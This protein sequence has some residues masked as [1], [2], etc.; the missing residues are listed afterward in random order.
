MAIITDEQIQPIV[1]EIAGDIALL[2]T[3]NAD[4][5]QQLNNKA[6]LVGGRVPS[7]QLPGY[8]DEVSEHVNFSELP[9]PGQASVI[10]VTTNDNKQYRWAGTSYQPIINSPGNT[11]AIPEGGTNKYFTA[12]RAAAAAPVQTVNGRAGNV[13]VTKAD[14]GLSQVTNT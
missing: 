10:Y 1:D 9:I 4:T 6:D 13:I 7:S 12:P 2:A 11:D 14:V 3:R 5:Q 8:V